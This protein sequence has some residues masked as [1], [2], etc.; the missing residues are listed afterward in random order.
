M[1]TVKTN[2]PTWLTGEK[3][4]PY[5]LT[6]EMSTN[7]SG[8]LF[9]NVDGSKDAELAFKFAVEAVNSQRD[10]KTDGLLEAGN[11]PFCVSAAL[12]NI[13]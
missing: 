6:G 7:S 10:S 1:K 2:N 5:S 11:S 9:D 3:C 13:H 8:G 4:L 12:A